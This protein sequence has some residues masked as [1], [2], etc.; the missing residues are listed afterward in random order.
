[1]IQ[2]KLKEIPD[3][4]EQR[5]SNEPNVLC[6]YCGYEPD[7]T[8]PEPNGDWEAEECG[9]CE[10]KYYTSASVTY[11]SKRDCKL[12][13]KECEWLPYE[14]MNLFSD[15]KYNW[16]RCPNCL[17]TKTVKREAEELLRGVE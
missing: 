16:F 4:K 15:R 17:E 2:E 13:E 5:T 12:N 7:E 10:K 9:R 8:Y 1:M 14:S 3:T 11:D 6:P